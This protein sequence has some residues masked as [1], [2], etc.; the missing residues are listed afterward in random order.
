MRYRP[1]E[2]EDRM[3][4]LQNIEYIS[5]ERKRPTEG[6]DR[7]FM[8]DKRFHEGPRDEEI[9]REDRFQEREEISY[10]RI[11]FI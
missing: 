5:N 6:E 1:T 11:D 8:R 10:E 7:D 2:G 4:K 9:S 3:K